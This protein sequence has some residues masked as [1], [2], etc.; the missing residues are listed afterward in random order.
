M[1][2][3]T[4]PNIE[5]ALGSVIKGL[6]VENYAQ[7]LTQ[8]RFLFEL[9]QTYSQIPSNL[10]FDSIWNQIRNYQIPSPD[11]VLYPTSPLILRFAG[12]AE[13][14]SILAPHSAGLRSRLCTSLLREFID[15]VLG[16]LPG[17]SG[18]RSY[19]PANLIA[20]G[21]NLGY[22]EETAIREHILQ[23]LTVTSGATL[24]VYQVV[25]LCVLFKIAGATFQAY[26]CP[27]V[28]DRCFEFLRGYDQ[29]DRARWQRVQV[30]E[31]YDRS[32]G[33]TKT[34]AGGNSTTRTWL[35]G[36]ASPAR[37]HG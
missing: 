36:P 12:D 22:I 25:A 14:D 17:V 6:S 35:G 27:S 29:Q 15:D 18:G 11:G 9:A 3:S 21:A 31:F 34:I 1:A 16:V 5:G 8:Y 24:R 28:V 2:T 13:L 33:G 23:L 20:H 4:M 30:S 26:T 32:L 10:V 37:T 19:I 7:S